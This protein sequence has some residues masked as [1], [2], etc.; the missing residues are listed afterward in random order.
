MVTSESV[1]VVPWSRRTA[2]SANRISALIRFAE[3]AVRLDQGTTAT[4]S[5][6]TIY[7]SN[8]NGLQADQVA[9]ANLSRVAAFNNGAD[10]IRL[11]QSNEVTLTDVVT[12][13]NTGGGLHLRSSPASLSSL[14]NYEDVSR[15]LYS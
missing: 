1:A 12:L 14:A 15:R 11:S 5:D 8:G 9:S 2:V 6:V 7:D 4:L 10:G 3:T 13:R